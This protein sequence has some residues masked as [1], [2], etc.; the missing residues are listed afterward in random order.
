M[1]LIQDP[2]I[3]RRGWQ[4]E[5]RYRVVEEEDIIHNLIVGGWCTNTHHDEIIAKEQITLYLNEAISSGLPCIE[6]GDIRKFD[7]VEV[8]NY[9]NWAGIAGISS[10]LDEACAPK[11][12]RLAMAAAAV[13]MGTVYEIRFKRTFNLAH[14]PQSSARRLRVPVPM[15]YSGLTLTAVDGLERNLIPTRISPDK[16]HIYAK[17]PADSCGQF[18][19]EADFTLAPDDAHPDQELTDRE[20]YLAP[21]EGFVVVTPRINRLA[22]DLTA[23][24]P[25]AR[26]QVER[27]FDYIINDFMHGAMHYDQLMR[28]TSPIDWV[29]DHGWHDCQLGSALMI[30]LCRAVGIPARMISGFF[31]YPQL[32]T[33]HYWVEVWLEE[34]GWIPYDLYAWP[35]SK[36]GQIRY[37]RDFFAGQIDRRFVDACMPD[38]FSGRP[39]V[40]FPPVWNLTAR[41]TDGGT[42]TRLGNVDTGEL[43]YADS[44]HFLQSLNGSVA[45]M[46]LA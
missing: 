11:A 28:Y 6:T 24:T 46:P 19:I 37:W 16:T 38:R 7:P 35:A 44:V 15:A 14:S 31:L 27:F 17:V 8:T 34:T 25:H 43:I 40:P 42:E 22:H 23:G 1:T 18:V 33:N 29:L 26:D 13:P 30:S 9:F 45:Q 10:M 20:R 4:S 39:G 2:R 32:S 36:G 5:A 41:N 12:H 3:D 21:V